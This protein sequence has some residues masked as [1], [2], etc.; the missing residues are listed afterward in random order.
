MLSGCGKDSKGTTTNT[1]NPTVSRKFKYKVT[2]SPALENGNTIT[3]YDVFALNIYGMGNAVDPYGYFNFNGSYDYN[4][5]LQNSPFSSYQDP[6]EYDVKTGGIITLSFGIMNLKS[7]G[8]K[9]VKVEFYLDGKI[10]KNV[11]LPAGIVSYTATPSP[12]YVYCPGSANSKGG[13]TVQ[14]TVP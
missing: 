5:S 12:T 6:N 8:C 3:G 11:D 2:V 7:L 4:G 1:P 13:G 10:Y 14:I 9:Q